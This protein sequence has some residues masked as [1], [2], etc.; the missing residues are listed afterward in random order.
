M[1]C[2]LKDFTGGIEPLNATKTLLCSSSHMQTSTLPKSHAA[3]CVK[4]AWI[5]WCDQEMI[6]KLSWTL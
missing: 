1:I 3:C 2:I 4:I 6:A 5:L